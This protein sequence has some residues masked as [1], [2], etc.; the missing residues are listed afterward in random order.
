MRPWLRALG[1]CVLVTAWFLSIQLLLFTTTL[2]ERLVD[3][4][5]VHNL[6]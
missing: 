6:Q 2:I 5:V 4:T 1:W 3:Y